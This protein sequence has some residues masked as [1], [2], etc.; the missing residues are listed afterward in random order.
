MPDF[1]AGERLG[2]GG[3]VGPAQ[4]G[5]RFER[6]RPAGCPGGVAFQQQLRSEGPQEQVAELGGR[7]AEPPRL[8][9]RQGDVGGQVL[10]GVDRAAEAVDGLMGVADDDGL[11]RLVQDDARASR[12]HV[13]GLV[14]E[15]DL[16]VDPGPGQRPD[17]EVVVMLDAQRP[18]GG[19]QP[20]VARVSLMS[21]QALRA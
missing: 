3:G 14:E 11:R 6:R 12:V 19:Q 13:L 9:E 20:G 4:D 5:V 8:G 16:G 21:A 17:L 1:Q 15:D 2:D 7:R 18:A 10:Q